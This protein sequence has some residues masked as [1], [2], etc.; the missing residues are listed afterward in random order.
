[1]SWADLCRQSSKPLLDFLFPAACPLCHEPAENPDG[2]PLGVCRPCREKLIPRPLVLC[3]GCGAPLG[4]FLAPSRQCFHCQRDTFAFSRAWSLGA[5]DGELRLAVLKAKEKN[6]ELMTAALADLLY[7][8]HRREWSEDPPEVVI[9]V[10]H[11]WTD[12]LTTAHQA[13]QTAA[14]R[15]ARRL[16]CKLDQR[17][18][19]K[20]TRTVRQASLNPTSRRENLRG[21]FAV[22]GKERLKGK[23]VFLV[24]D[25]LTTG[26]T[27]QRVASLLIREAGAKDVRVC[28]LARGIGRM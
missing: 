3:Q 14:L 4:P 23:R 19:V 1:M 20:H 28:V 25:V 2:S 16:H 11:H 13:S 9:A 27:A 22:R 5:F 10:P 7:E 12:R 8:L 18:I 26:T 17:T 15:L 6:G 21:A 24:D